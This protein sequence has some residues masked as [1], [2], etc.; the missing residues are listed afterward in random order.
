MAGVIWSA[1]FFV[2]TLLAVQRQKPLPQFAFI[3]LAIFD[4][5]SVVVLWKVVARFLRTMREREP[6]VD[7]DRDAMCYGESAN[8]YLVEPNPDNIDEL[9]VKLVGECWAKSMTEFS[10][11]RRTVVEYSRCYEEELLRFSPESDRPLRRKVKMQ[12]PKSAPADA[13]QWKIVVGTR[14][15]QGGVIEHPFPLRVSESIIP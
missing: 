3:L 8:L 7:I 11:Y 5:I 2:A 10:E 1:A 9:A 12:L 13:V 15:K 6:I 14:L 4:L